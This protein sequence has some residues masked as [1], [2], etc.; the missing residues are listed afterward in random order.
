MQEHYY[1]DYYNAELTHWWFRARRHIVAALLRQFAPAMR[2]LRVADVGCG[3]GANFDILAEFGWVVGVDYS[4]TALAFS[5][6][7][8]HTRLVSAALPKLPFADGE[9]DAVCALDVIEHIDDDRAAV[10]ELWRVCKPQGLLMVTVP[11]YEWL[12]SKHDDINEHKRRYTRGRLQACLAQPQ[13]EFLRLSYMNTILAPPLMLFRGAKNFAGKRKKN[14]HRPRSDVFDCPSPLNK[15]LE[16]LF[17]AEAVWLRHSTL[18]FG[19][20]LVCVARKHAT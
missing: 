14:D 8:G 3:M 1:Q 13:A 7:R 4:P 16:K 5:L 19:V 15:L 12:W 18:P 2:P 10:R 6:G 20:S 17:S 9:F 11:A